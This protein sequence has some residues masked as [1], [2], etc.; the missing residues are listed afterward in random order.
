MDGTDEEWAVLIAQARLD[1]P[2]RL[3]RIVFNRIVE[4]FMPQMDSIFPAGWIQSESDREQEAVWI[5]CRLE[6][7]FHQLGLTVVDER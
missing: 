1:Q 5:L 2:W 4:A 7:V 6:E 3:D